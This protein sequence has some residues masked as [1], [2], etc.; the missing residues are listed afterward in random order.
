[1]SVME[2][3]I[4]HKRL[5]IK[6]DMLREINMRCML[7]EDCKYINTTVQAEIILRLH[8]EQTIVTTH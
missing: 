6:T 5:N 1:M 4:I 3:S 8:Q 2:R 7:L